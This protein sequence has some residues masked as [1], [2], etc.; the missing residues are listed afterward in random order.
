MKLLTKEIQNKMPFTEKAVI[1]DLNELPIIVKYF[2]GASYSLF[3]VSADVILAD[4]QLVKLKDVKNVDDK[5]EVQDVI[6]YGYVK[7]LQQDEFGYTSFNE[8]KALRFPPFGLRVERD[9]YFD[10]KKIKDII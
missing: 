7:G 3:V 2:G 6:F 8:L 10:N 9:M 5:N 4:G 1:E